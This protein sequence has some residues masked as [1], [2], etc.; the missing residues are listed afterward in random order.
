MVEWVARKPADALGLGRRRW[1]GSLRFWGDRADVPT[2]LSPEGS[3]G[4]RRRLAPQDGLWF[5]P[6][7]AAVWSR[8]SVLEGLHSS[9]TAACGPSLAALRGRSLRVPL[10][11][12][13]HL[14]HDLPDLA[15]RSLASKEM[16]DNSDNHFL[17]FIWRLVTRHDDFR[18]G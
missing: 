6:G 13:L 8:P 17:V 3:W 10:L 2:A 7:L 5:A 4:L 15:L 11:L 18:T 1:V 12:L 14:L 16:P 9:C